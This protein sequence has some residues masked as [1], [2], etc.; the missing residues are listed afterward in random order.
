MRLLIALALLAF[1]LMMLAAC[2]SP[3]S[4]TE[5]A[6]GTGGASVRDV[7]G[8]PCSDTGA[9]GCPSA[10]GQAPAEFNLR[11]TA[12]GWVFHSTCD[13]G[14]LCNHFSGSTHGECLKPAFPCDQR[15]PGDRICTKTG[16]AV[17]GENIF[18]Y[19]SARDCG[20][21]KDGECLTPGDCLEGSSVCE[22]NKKTVCQGGVWVDGGACKSL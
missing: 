16:D 9:L 4:E 19:A 8:G 17:C 20:P 12:K 14:T 15:Q 7:E 1:S 18:Y 2:G 11:C 5:S 10:P 3:V 21:C 13:K 22:D 6:G